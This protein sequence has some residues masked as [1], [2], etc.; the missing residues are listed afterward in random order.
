[1]LPLTAS[2]V[3]RPVKLVTARS[4]ESITLKRM[5]PS[6]VADPRKLNWSIEPL[7]G[8]VQL[9]AAERRGRGGAGQQ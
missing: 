3:M 1:M 4:A 2:P 7:A 9:P 5:F 8:P 6:G